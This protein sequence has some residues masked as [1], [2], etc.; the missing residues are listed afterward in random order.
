[1]EPVG[2]GK[3]N[4]VIGPE[5]Q[6]LGEFGGVPHQVGIDRQHRDP[7]PLALKITLGSLEIAFGDVFHATPFRQRPSCL[8]IRD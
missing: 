3:M 1:M 5:T 6:M 2:T 8:N 7:A 4:G